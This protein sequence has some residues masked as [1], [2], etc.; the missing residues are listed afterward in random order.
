MDIVRWDR[1]V[2]E[3]ELMVE[4]LVVPDEDVRIR[5]DLSRV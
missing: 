2:N 3:V 1:Q 5:D 4:V